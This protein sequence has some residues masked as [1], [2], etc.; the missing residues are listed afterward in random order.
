[1]LAKRLRK[2]LS[3]CVFAAGSLMLLLCLAGCSNAT[4]AKTVTEDDFI[5]TWVVESMEYEGQTI[6]SAEMETAGISFSLVIGKD[7]YAYISD[8]SEIVKDECSISGNELV[9]TDALDGTKTYF[10]LRGDKLVLDYSKTT[11]P[12]AEKLDSTVTFKRV[13]DKSNQVESNL[14]GRWKGYDIITDE[15]STAEPLSS[16]G[17]TA[18]LDINSKMTGTFIWKSSSSSSS[19]NIR[20][21]A[22]GITSSYDVYDASTQEKIASLSYFNNNGTEWLTL[23]VFLDGGSYM[24]LSFK[25]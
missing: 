17:M 24:Q 10:E 2:V 12:S 14:V 21:E 4:K 19:Y 23:N 3:L 22:S 11:G 8:G 16:Y 9:I 1:M 7:G 20:I 6:S 15:M 18:Q 25:K 5:G 13:L